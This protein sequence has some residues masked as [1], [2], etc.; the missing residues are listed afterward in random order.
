MTNFAL[1]TNSSAGDIVSSLNYALAN[2]GTGNATTANIG[3]VLV[4]DT[5]TGQITNSS[6]GSVVAYLY[7]WV[8]IRYANSPDGSVGFSASPTNTTYYGIQNTN[9]ANPST[10]NNPSSYIWNLAT[11]GFGTT[12]YLFYSTFGGYQIVFY[13]GATAPNDQYRQTVNST[14]IDL[15][16]ITTVSGNIGANGSTIFSP[17][18]FYRA[19]TA[20]ATPTGGTYNF[21]NLFLVPPIGWLANVPS[22]SGTTV[23]SSINTFTS[24]AGATVAPSF[25]WTTPTIFT[26]NG[27]TGA[28]GA[29]GNTGANGSAG[30]STFVLTAFTVGNTRPNVPQANTGSWNFATGTGTPPIDSSAV[31]TWQLTQPSPT[32]YGPV[33]SSSAT[34]FASNANPTA[35][36]TTLTWGN[37]NVSTPLAAPTLAVSYPQ[38]Q[39][40]VSNNGT[41]TPTP[42]ANVVTLTANVQALRGNAILAAI[43]QNTKYFIANGN[44]SI[45]SNVSTGFNANALVFATPVTNLY[46]AYQTVVYA[47]AGGNAVGYLSEALL[48]TTTGNTGPQGFTPMAY[49]VA[50]VNPT[51][52]NTSILNAMYTAPRTNVVP[53]IGAGYA[54][55]AQDVAQFF[56]PN[57][58]SYYGGVTAVYQYDGVN[59]TT[60]TGQVISGNLLVAGTITADRLNVN[61]IYTLALQSTNATFGSPSSNGFW[62]ASQTGDARFAGNTYIGDNLIVGQNAQIGSNLNVGTNA[63]VGNN[64]RVG[65]NANIGNNLLVGQNA[66]IGDNLYVGQNTQIGSNLNVGTNATISNNLTVGQ[67]TQIG[68]NLNVGT[69]AT[70]SNNLFVGNNA[71]IGGNLT[72]AGLVNNGVLANAVVGS[73]QLVPGTIPNAANVVYNI[74]STTLTTT[75][76]YDGSV[77]GYGYYK[78]LCYNQIYSNPSWITGTGPNLTITVSAYVSFSGIT[79]SAGTGY[80]QMYMYMNAPGYAGPY[81]F[82][83]PTLGAYGYTESLYD[84]V[85]S[86]SGSFQWTHTFVFTSLS[87]STYWSNTYPTTFGLSVLNSISPFNTGTVTV[88]NINISTV[89][90]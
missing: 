39:Y 75:G 82:T 57:V 35:N 76:T 51:T 85:G 41:Y 66:Q 58:S 86:T 24:N 30:S 87:G 46:N 45:S 84:N 20:P 53:P 17:T 15:A 1:D 69:N 11:G 50:N 7:E 22:G 59:W 60:V 31:Y 12:K 44:Y 73:A 56:Y 21:G 37:V 32:L 14:P 48:Q 25:A 70:I 8:N 33:W 61:N 16:I 23:Y 6:N 80:P 64:L 5:N 88:T 34:A 71:Q 77:S 89:F 40:V 10:I 28:T 18:I 72:I 2:L 83:S 9:V 62:L 68:S 3:N 81:G 52:A 26:A 90:S 55:V 65:T 63:V 43:T 67:N 29:T 19:N 54:P 13:A 79:Y 27:A 49:I 78:I 74:G 36:V 38:G 42:V 4:T 47:D